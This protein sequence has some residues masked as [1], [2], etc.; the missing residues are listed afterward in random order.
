MGPPRP[1]AEQIEK[2][3]RILNEFDIGVMTPPDARNRLGLAQFK[4]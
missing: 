2:I 3:K 4:N 1:N